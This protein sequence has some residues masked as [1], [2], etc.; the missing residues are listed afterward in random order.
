MADAERYDKMKN[1][2]KHFSEEV[3]IM[4]Y[5]DLTKEQQEKAKACK[6]PEEIFAFAKEI[7][8]ELSE[9]EI[10]G[11]SGGGEWEPCMHDF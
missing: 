4:K 10:D 3:L 11:I 7:G 8:Y 5:E 2:E 1:I 9:K 6:T